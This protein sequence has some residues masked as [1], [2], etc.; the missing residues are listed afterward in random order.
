MLE[1]GSVTGDTG[2]IYGR[3]VVLFISPG[4]NHATEVWEVYR[5]WD[6]QR[7]EDDTVIVVHPHRDDWRDARPDDYQTYR[8][9]LEMELTA[10]TQAVTTAHQARIAEYGGR[11][12]PNDIQG[13]AED[14]DLPMLVT[15]ANLLLQFYT[16]TGAY[17]HADGPPAQPPPPCGLAVPDQ[18]NNPDLMR[19]CINL[20]AAKD[21]LRGTA[22]LNW[23]VDTP[24][25]DWDGVTVQGSPS[26]VKRLVLVEDSLTGT[27]PPELGR[28][29]GLEYLWLGYNQ[30]TGEI[31]AAL[32][33]LSNL[34]SLT[35]NQNQLTGAIPRDLGR[36]SRLEAIW[37][38]E[39]QLVE[40]RDPG[41]AGRPRQP[42][43][44]APSGQPAVRSHPVSSGR[45]V[46]PGES[47]AQLQPA[48]RRGTS[49]VGEPEQS[50]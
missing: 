3:E 5:T 48:D 18:A 13:R 2:G 1:R 47:E 39:N 19:D 10:F 21:A 22:T 41:V 30:L 49:G 45:P 16:D 14:V 29:D 26:R 36:L 12:A 34:K 23:S 42:A 4:N 9:A 32:G 37:L 50:G 17:N 31:P 35:L 20:L 44:T 46:Q 24:I 8:S 43:A 40:R 11:I 7:Q 27:L 25:S 28:L 33:G 38:N 6:V 15:D